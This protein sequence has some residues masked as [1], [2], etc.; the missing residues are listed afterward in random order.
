MR[1]ALKT[2]IIWCIILI[3]AERRKG[4]FVSGFGGEER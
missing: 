3:G 2:A 4:R 1:R